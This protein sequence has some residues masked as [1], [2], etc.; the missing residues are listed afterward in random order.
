MKKDKEPKIKEVEL[1]N[2]VE[3][4][5]LRD[6]PQGIH[7]NEVHIDN[8]KKGKPVTIPRLF[9]QNMV[10]EKVINEIPE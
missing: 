2:E 6:F 7:H 5:P 8:I 1:S 4:M 10:T 9:L 3:I